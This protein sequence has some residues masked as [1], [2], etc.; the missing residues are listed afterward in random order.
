MREDEMPISDSALN[1]FAGALADNIAC[2]AIGLDIDSAR[3]V[4][5][6]P[7]DH[8]LTGFLTPMR[9]QDSADESD[10]DERLVDDLPQDSAYEQ[11]AMG[12]E[13]LAPKDAFRAGST[14]TV[15][16][17]CS[18]YVRRLPSYLEQSGAVVW[19]VDGRGARQRAAAGTDDEDTRYTPLVP[20]WTRQ[21]LSE[22]LTHPLELADVIGKRRIQVSLADKLQRALDVGRDLAPRSELRVPE[23]VLRTE[24]SYVT[25]LRTLPEQTAIP[26]WQPTIDVRVASVPMEPDCVRVALRLINFTRPPANRYQ[27]EFVDPNLYAVQI[28]AQIPAAAHKVTIFRELPQS[29]RYDRLMAGVGI[30]AHVQCR[31]DHGYVILT[32]DA[33]PRTRA[34]RLEPR[35]LPGASPRFDTLAQDPLPLLRA[36]LERMRA[37][38]ADAWATKLRSLSG[39]DLQEAEH[40]RESFRREIAEFAR[41]I[42]VLADESRFPAVGRAFRLMN[43]V[44]GQ[45]GRS[46]RSPFEEW[47]LFQLV[48]IVS[49]L[50]ALAARE[51]ADLRG[52]QDDHSP[53]PDRVDLLWFAAGGGKTEAFLGLLLWQ[54]FFDRIRGKRLGVTAFV[55]FPLRL[56]TFQQLQRLGRA[57]GIA[58]LIRAREQLGG[59]RFSLGYFVGGG[60]TDNKITDDAHR[61]YSKPPLDQRLRRVFECPFC[62]ASTELRY[63]AAL[64]LLEHHCTRPN[65]PG[66]P[67]RLPIY[68]V[69]DD[70]YRYL[71]TVIV[72]TVDK[73]AGIGQNQRFANLLGRVDMVCPEHGA[74]FLDVNAGRCPAAKER[75]DGQRPERCGEGTA[76]IFYGPFYD[77]GPA[78]LIQDELHLLSEEL[79]TFDAHYET[80]V[81]EVSRSLGYQPWKV[82]AA[83]ATIQEY[84]HHAWQLYLKSAKQFPAPGPGAYESFYYVLNTDKIGR[85]FIG[86]V[87][88]GRKHTPAVTR[89]LAITYLE[90]DAARRLAAADPVEAGVTYRTGSLTAD[91][92][93]TLLFLYE[94]PLTYALT[95]KGSDQVAEA[96]ESRVKKELNDLAPGFGELLIQMFNGGV[97]PSEMIEAMQAIRD[98]APSSDPSS[99]TRGLVATNVIGHGVD[100]D[101]FNI[102]VFAGF[103]RL[104]A[105]YIQA[106]ARVGRTY[107]GLSILV[108]TPQSERD[109]GVFNRFAKFHEYLDR[110][111]DPSAIIRW[112]LPAIERT[113]PGI[114]SSYLMGVAPTK[115][116]ALLATVEHVQHQQGRS[117]AE[118]LTS[119]AIVEWMQAAYG[120][121]HA[122]SRDIYMERLVATVKR[123]HA[124]II[125]AQ[126]RT[127]GPRPLNIY[128]GAMRS[129]RDID[130]P[131][132]IRAQAQADEQ[133]LRRLVRG[134]I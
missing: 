38:D 117:G 28:E 133:V 25:W 17:S 57:I 1:G 34:H 116:G 41:G 67:H 36:I 16:V 134:G 60:V 76:R 70:L 123:Y 73:M 59:Q 80:A 29:Y 126:A 79:G 97:D 45:V 100:I 49:Q 132:E 119:P 63:N 52:Q 53:E 37:Y 96:I 95:R 39:K 112:P 78:L 75:K 40:D 48:F 107:P 89:T 120:S 14:L 131:A 99:R 23:A 122:P 118:A 35:Q 88:V 98:T 74:S 82:I 3:I 94:L 83:T 128:L 64:R 104:V 50:P 15:A 129:L 72:S 42:D 12:F 109:R 68:I 54:A 4:A 111:V 85:I 84:R 61:R 24:A 26:K 8:I 106:S 56:L 124:M 127:G 103:P 91:E 66:G 87:G 55:R 46:G 130:D 51:Y 13:W 58:E 10:P 20:V 2:R 30:N 69:D 105:E 81:A 93:R 19:R 27:L 22:P 92:W 31:H 90:L 71:P 115:V 47:R 65:C 9:R 43:E 102:M 7:S 5:A 18:V 108:A 62:Q 125:N 32:S 113:V 6:R 86:L 121:V 33:V 110:L 11:T 21:T 77:P 44:M 114:L 101:R